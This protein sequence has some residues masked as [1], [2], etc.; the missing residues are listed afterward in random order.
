MTKLLLILLK[1][2]LIPGQNILLK[3]LI[4]ILILMNVQNVLNMTLF[5]PFLNLV[6]IIMILLIFV[7]LPSFHVL[8]KFKKNI[9]LIVL[10]GFLRN[11]TYMQIFSLLIVQVLV[12]Q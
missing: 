3:F 11:I 2:F 10:I 5:L 4:I 7:P 6:V 12:P 1:V 8:Q 9:L